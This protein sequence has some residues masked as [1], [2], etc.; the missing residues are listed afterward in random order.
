MSLFL[1]TFLPG[2][3]CAALGGLL[4]SNHSLVTASLKAFP[5]SQTAA[6]LAFGGAAAW[7]L[8][9][10]W[11][12]SPADNFDHPVLFTVGF[13]AVAVLSFQCVPDFL[14][15]RG[16]ATLVLLVA[17]HLR[18]AAYMEYDHPQRLLMVGPLFVAVALAIWLGVQPFRLRDFFEWLFF[19]P[20]RPRVIGGLLAAYGVML[21][22]ASFTY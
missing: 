13:A 15:V 4:A 5:R 9:V 3:F 8:W 21:V 2:L 11:N 7:F 17:W 10:T 16:L 22:I 20:S 14:A 1:A 18:G 6:Y 12:S 19:R